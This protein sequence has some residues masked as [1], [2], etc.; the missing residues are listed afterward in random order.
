LRPASKESILGELIGA[1]WRRAMR[2]STTWSV[3]ATLVVS[4]ASSVALASTQSRVSGVVVDSGGVPI[5]GAEVTVTCPEA[6]A[7]KKVLKTDGKGQFKI[8][9]LDATKSY[10]FHTEAPGYIPYD[11]SVKVP[12]GTNDNELTFT[13]QSEQEADAASKDQIL[14]QPGYKEY[15]EGR[16]LLKADDFAGAYAKFSQAVEAV[17]D[18]AQAW[19]NLADIDFQNADYAKAM[20]NAEICLEHDDENSKCLAVA[21]NSANELGDS[22]A[23]QRYLAR[24]QEINPDD[25]ATLFNQAVDHLNALDDEN[26]RP[27]LEQCL[28]VDD[29]FGQ[30]LFEYGMLLLRTGDLEGA[31]AHLNKYLEVAPDG[32]DATAA[33]ETVKYL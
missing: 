7:Y 12:A 25:P 14:E 33:R 11:E 17:P 10:I 18:L 21:A 5:S 6:A 30:C 31:K 27:Y 29:E 28:E 4:V 3:V 32:P 9:L 19:A 22:E 8:L 1:V 26:A 15:E 20:E 24:Y 16:E 13:L 23:E 2:K